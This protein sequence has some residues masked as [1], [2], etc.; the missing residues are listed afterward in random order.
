MG[1]KEIDLVLKQV[2][3]GA[4]AVEKETN[5]LWEIEDLLQAQSNK[6][7]QNQD[8]VI[9]PTGEEAV[10]TLYP[11][12]PNMMAKSAQLNSEPIAQTSH[13]LLFGLPKVT[14]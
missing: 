1:E 13:F 14:E 4:C 6:E 11:G 2:N 10:T 8:M 7:F 5:V 12:C 3:K 9:E